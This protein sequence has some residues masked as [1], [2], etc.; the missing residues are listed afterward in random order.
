M[1][2]QIVSSLK[3]IFKDEEKTKLLQNILQSIQNNSLQTEIEKIN[4]INNK[5]DEIMQKKEETANILQEMETQQKQINNIY[6][7]IFN[8]ENGSSSE[9]LEDIQKAQECAQELQESYQK[10]YDTKDSQGNVMQGII[11]KLDKACNQIQENEQK[12]NELDRF[13]IKVF[14]GEK[15]EKGEIIQKSLQDTLDEHTKKL[16]NL[17]SS[18]ENELN[19]LISERK[20]KLTQLYI[21]KEQ[22]INSLLPGATTAGLANAYKDE[23]NNID[24]SIVRW[25]RIFVCSIVV[26]IGSF[27]VYFYLSFQENFTY[28]SFLRS[29]PFWIFSGFFT[30]YST[31]QIAR[32]MRLQSEYTHKETLNATYVGYKR[33]MDESGD[34]NELKSKLLEIMLDSAKLNPSNTLEKH[35]GEIASLTMMEKMLDFLPFDSLKKLKEIIDKKLSAKN[36]EQ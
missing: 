33:Q 21:G 23:K 7:T 31:K 17:Y 22:E 16:N 28:I 20:E 19:T 12:I 35:K 14:D 25:N 13:Y 18:K 6:Q 15:N 34:N 3:E 5:Y 27:G 24:K 4:D 29:L 11:T 36:L 26:F 30:Y 10:F 1:E 2:Q 9:A 8:K 32:Y